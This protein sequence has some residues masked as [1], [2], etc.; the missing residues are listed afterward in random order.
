[1]F[2]SLTTLMVDILTFLLNN[3]DI[4]SL[5]VCLIFL[6]VLYRSSITC[7]FFPFV[8]FYLYFK[9]VEKADSYC[10][11]FIF[12]KGIYIDKV[13]IVSLIMYVIYYG[14]L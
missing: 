7:V 12:K 11:A 8:K 2:G 4:L 3:S 6:V 13:L 5:L 9:Q 14:S 10:D 1:M